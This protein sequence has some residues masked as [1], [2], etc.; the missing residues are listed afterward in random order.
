MARGA[1]PT[2]PSLHNSFT[3][4]PPRYASDRLSP[5]GVTLTMASGKCLAG[6]CQGRIPPVPPGAPASCWRGAEFASPPQG[7]SCLRKLAGRMPAL[8]VVV[9]QKRPCASVGS[10]SAPGPFGARRSSTRQHAG[11]VSIASVRRPFVHYGFL[12]RYQRPA[13]A[14]LLVTTYCVPF[15]A[16][17]GN[18]GVQSSDDTLVVHSSANPTELVG[19]DKTML[20]VSRR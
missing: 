17:Y 18:A 5:I 2:A 20:L 15:T 11:R 6:V 12:S 14:A 7:L 19:Q 16:E 3:T 9:R 4:A 1:S 13:P 8:P 10:T